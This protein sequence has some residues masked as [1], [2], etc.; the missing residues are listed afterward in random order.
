ME[1]TV[2]NTSMMYPIQLANL[3]AVGHM[4]LKCPY[5]LSTFDI[6]LIPF[7]SEDMGERT[8]LPFFIES[9]P[10]VHVLWNQVVFNDAPFNETHYYG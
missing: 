1:L 8:E 10:S 2:A 5:S 6:P 3:V 7:P 4:S 9:F